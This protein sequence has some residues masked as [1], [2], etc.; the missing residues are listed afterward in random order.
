MVTF[1]VL[2]V[3]KHIR[4]K[5]PIIWN[6]QKQFLW[7]FQTFRGIFKTSKHRVFTAHLHSLAYWGSNVVNTLAVNTFESF[8]RWPERHQREFDFP[9]NC[10][11]WFKHQNPATRQQLIAFV[12]N[13]AETLNICNLSLQQSPNKIF[14]WCWIELR[15]EKIE[16]SARSNGNYNKPVFHHCL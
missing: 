8:P 1:V 13:G 10:R 7:Q 3:L 4:N 2:T 9:T 5:Y 11:A 12:E 16:F 14:A 6:F 15:S